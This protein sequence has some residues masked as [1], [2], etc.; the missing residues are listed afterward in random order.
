[1]QG[2]IPKEIAENNW[3]GSEKD[4]V[5]DELIGWD[6][7]WSYT[8]GANHGL[9]PHFEEK[10]LEILPDGTK[11]IQNGVGVIE[12]VKPG[13]TSIPSEDDYLLKDREAFE[14]LY[15]PKMQFSPERVDVEYFKTFNETRD[16]SRPIGLNLGSV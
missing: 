15:K 8:K 1:M 6:F 9:M 2:K 11:R 16:T 14:T 5:L 12:K 7:N 10:V 3:D 4:R 13:L